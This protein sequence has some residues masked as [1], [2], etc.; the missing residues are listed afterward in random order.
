[1][2]ARPS[3]DQ[4]ETRRELQRAF[5]A[6]VPSGGL[7][8][9]LD[10]GCGER[11]PIDIPRGVHLSGIDIST[12][13][14]AKNRNADELILGDIQSYALP[15][16]AFDAVICWW[17]LEHL[18]RPVDALANMSSCLAPGGLLVLGIPR[19]YSMKALITKFTPYRFHVWVVRRFYGVANAGAPGIEPYPT[20]LRRELA[21][22]RLQKL[23]TQDQLDLIYSVTHRSGA[24][25]TLPPAMRRLWNA[26]AKIAE[27]C[28]FGRWDPYSDEYVAIFQKRS[29]SSSRPRNF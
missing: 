28:T 25:K 16:N 19:L 8:K 22:A 27:A 12:D 18:P 1:M 14:L 23:L 11:L 21:P 13:A 7:H 10:A 26:T 29:D 4:D 24:E 17:V 20:Y 9:V 5:E 3:V 6:R 2:H 15:K